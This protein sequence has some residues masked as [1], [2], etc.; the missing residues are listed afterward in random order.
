MVQEKKFQ[1]NFLL[2]LVSSLKKRAKTKVKQSKA[3]P[4]KQARSVKKNTPKKSKAT[5]QQ[6]KVVKARK[7]RVTKPKVEEQKPEEKQL[8]CQWA[9]AVF[10]LGSYH[11]T[12][13]KDKIALSLSKELSFD[14]KVGSPEHNKATFEILKEFLRS[15]LDNKEISVEPFPLVVSIGDK[16]LKCVYGKN[17]EFYVKISAPKLPCIQ[18]GT[19]LQKETSTFNHLNSIIRKEF[20][21]FVGFIN[22]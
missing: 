1:K 9:K 7:K 10:H 16:Q 14:S 5:P 18:G 3:K 4:A 13:I 20:K 22:I 2:G 12:K 17:L 15:C 21:G 6:K 19:P 8:Q 11:S